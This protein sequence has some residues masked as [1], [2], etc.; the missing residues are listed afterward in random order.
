MTEMNRDPSLVQPEGSIRYIALGSAGAV[1][2][3]SS[4]R[5]IKTPLNLL[6]TM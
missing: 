6:S 2:L 1:F 3:V 4:D 5:V